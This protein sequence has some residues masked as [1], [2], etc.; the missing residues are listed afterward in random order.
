M[1]KIIA[2][3][4]L[5]IASYAT[6]SI[7][8][9]PIKIYFWHSMSAQ[10]GMALQVI[11]DGFNQSQ[12]KYKVIGVYKGNYNEALTALVAAFRAKQQPATAQVFEIGTATMMA[13]A[14][15][16]VPV[17]QL[18]QNNGYPLNPKIFLPAIAAYYSDSDGQLMSMPF[19]ASAPVLYYNKQ[20]FIK[21]GL[22]PNQPPSTWPLLAADG[23]KLLKAGYSCAY[24]TTWPAWIQLESFSAW[25]NIP[26]ATADNGFKS[27]QVQV[28][29]NNPLILRQLT[30]LANWQKTG[31]FEY[32]GQED[33]AQSLFV[34]FYCRYEFF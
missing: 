26:Y 13:S 31:I 6:A 23:E 32:G 1:K 16:I 17:Y 8:N 33:D 21:A 18:M 2:V 15:A 27:Y 7:P 34:T 19:N 25:H 20:A 3:I 22:D 12:Q 10:P 11:I 14:G 5:V 4:F 28:L 30:A 9:K 29:Y 24:T